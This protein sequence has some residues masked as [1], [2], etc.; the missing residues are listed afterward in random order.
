MLLEDVVNQLKY[1]ELRAISVKDDNVAIVSYVN[2]AVQ[3]LYN[4]FMLKI[5]TQVISLDPLINTYDLAD[6]IML[7]DKIIDESG[8]EILLDDIE[9]KDKLS[10]NQT[11]FNT[12]EVTNIQDHTTLTITYRIAPSFLVYIDETSLQ[13]IVP[14][15]PQLLE[16]LLHYVGYRAYGSMDSTL[17]TENNTHYM[18]FVASCKEIERLGLI[19]RAIPPKTINSYEGISETLL[20]DIKE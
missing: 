6:D 7:I 14:I 12:I 9:Q 10:I 19:R 1:G 16:P 20:N 11:S 13:Q 3:A 17:K 18:R 15:P 2:L 8:T 5:S 4:R